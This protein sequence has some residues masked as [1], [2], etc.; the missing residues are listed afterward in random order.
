MKK[1]LS[2][3]VCTSVALGG[4][5][6]AA[7]GEKKDPP[8]PSFTIAN[9]V[10]EQATKIVDELQTDV[11]NNATL[12]KDQSRSYDEVQEALE[13]TDHALTEGYWVDCGTLANMDLTQVSSIQLGGVT[14]GKTDTFKLSV[15]NNNFIEDKVFTIEDGKVK[16][17]AP[18]VAFELK[19]EESKLTVGSNEFAFLTGEEADELQLGK[20]EFKNNANIADNDGKVTNVV[21]PVQDNEYDLKLSSSDDYLLLTPNTEAEPAEDELA[22]DGTFLIRS[23]VDGK[24]EKFGITGVDEEGLGIYFGRKADNTVDPEIDGKTI[25][26]D[27]YYTETVDDVTTHKAAEFT[28]NAEIVDGN[29]QLKAKYDEATKQEGNKTIVLDKDVVLTEK[30]TV[31]KEVTIDLKG[32]VITA[33]NIDTVTMFLITDNGILTIKDSVGAGKI[34]SKSSGYVFGVLNNSF[35]KD[36]TTTNLIVESGEFETTSA[37]VIYVQKGK[38]VVK[39]G[40]FK[41]TYS[42]PKYEN[43]DFSL[44]CE[45]NAS[46]G[47]TAV[48]EVVGGKFWKFNPGQLTNNDNVKSYLPAGL[49]VETAEDW[50]T[51]VAAESVFV[52]DE[53]ELQDAVKYVKDGGTVGLKKSFA[54]TKA[55]EINKTLKLDL[56]SKTLNE[57][58]E[59]N[60]SHCMFKIVKGGHLTVVNNGILA[61]GKIVANNTH[62]FQVYNQDKADTD[63]SLLIKK[64]TFE[65]SDSTCVIQLVYG[66]ATVEGGTFKVTS[67]N[68]YY[69]F[70][71]IDGADQGKEDG[72]NGLDTAKITVKGGTYE[73][74][75]GTQ[76]VLSDDKT[77]TD[78][79]VAEGY[80]VAEAGENIKQVVAARQVSVSNEEELIAALEDGQDGD[81]IQL[82]GNIVLTK[83]INAN[84]KFVLDLNGHKIT[85]NIT[86][87]ENAQ[88]LINITSGG[89]LVVK[90]SDVEKQGAIETSNYSIFWLRGGNKS[91]ATLVIDGGSFSSSLHCVYATGGTAIINDGSFKCTGARQDLLLNI[92]D[93]EPNG[94]GTTY[95]EVTEI[96][97]NGGEFKDFQVETTNSKDAN[98]KLGDGK[99]TTRETKNENET[100]W[101]VENN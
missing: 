5:A 101:K 85:E 72:R 42:D 68:S 57:T 84:F 16:I 89:V 70:N 61:G 53:N 65:V 25:R 48:I 20:A 69:L 19:E 83:T 73:L 75:T 90:D 21:T 50:N 36:G 63:A 58:I 96:I 6:L 91:R 66:E 30:F 99:K 3:V 93:D 8:K 4:V 7:C 56:Y 39:G 35:V 81:T 23:V 71:G 28:F 14:Y 95:A 34:V 29:A 38:A 44:N 33:E 27:V 100:W 45:D 54:L 9:D 98:I 78:A 51:V 87:E 74:G 59:D 32:H 2:L 60:V 11:Y 49:A 62:I 10:E 26:Q 86:D 80:V 94:E 88:A 43:N 47:G 92:H 76:L 12:G 46:K 52:S 64:G 67:G 37:S 1:I 13:D 24:A 55:V 97:V 18:V 31:D 82:T 15:G 17:A 77:E 41:C 79:V 22:E 40:T